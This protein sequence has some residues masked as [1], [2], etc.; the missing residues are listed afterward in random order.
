MPLASM[1]NVTSICGMPRGDGGI[2]SRLNSPRALLPAAISRSPWNT[3]IV[4]AG[5]LSSAVEKVCENRVGIVVFFWII[6]VITPPRVSIPSD[7][8]VTSSSSTS[9]RSPDSTEP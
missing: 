2:P 8:G 1:S 9:L 3:L 4:T 7:R 6:F 5:W